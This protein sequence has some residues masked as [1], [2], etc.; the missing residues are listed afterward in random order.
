MTYAEDYAAQLEATAQAAQQWTEGDVV[1]R[2]DELLAAIDAG[3]CRNIGVPPSR[4]GRG[5]RPGDQPA[6]TADAIIARRQTRAE[7]A[8]RARTNPSSLT[9]ADLAHL[10]PGTVAALVASGGLAH[11][12]VGGTR[13][14]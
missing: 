12:G 14:R 1:A 5:P 6:N 13:R 8:D 3:L 4:A 7:V 2:P 10:D 9:D 11:L